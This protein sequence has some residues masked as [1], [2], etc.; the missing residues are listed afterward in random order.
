MLK[1]ELCLG[2]LNSI[3]TLLTDTAVIVLSPKQ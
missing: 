1:A 3:S 2:I